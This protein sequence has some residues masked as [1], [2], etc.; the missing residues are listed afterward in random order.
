MQ[1]TSVSPSPKYTMFENGMGLSFLGV[2]FVDAL[3]QVF[4]AFVDS[5][6]ALGFDCVV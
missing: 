1:G 4:P 2:L 5:E 3:P 6:K